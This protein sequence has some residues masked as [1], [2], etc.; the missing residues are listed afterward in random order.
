MDLHSGLPYWIIKNEL[1]DYFNPLDAD[2]ETEVVIIGSGITGSLV[3]HE[4]CEAKIPCVMIDK[5]TIATG[6][7]AASTSQLQYEI[8]VP[9]SE[10]IEKVGEEKAVKA[11]KDCL[12]SITD[13]ENIYKKIKADPDFR[14]VPTTLLASN[15]KGLKLL[16]KEYEIRKKHDLPVDFL[17]KEELKEQLNLDAPGALYNETSAQMDCYKGATSILKYHLKQSNF[18][19]FSHTL[20]TDYEETSSGYK[21]LTEG[22]N[23]IKCKYVIIAAGFEAGEFLPKKVM[24]LLSTYVI[25]SQPV[26]EDML[27]KNRSLIWETKEPYL[28]MRTTVD[29]RIIVG[30]EDISFSN[31]KHRDSRLRNKIKKLEI[32]FKKMFPE[33]PFVT[34][35]AWCGT[36]SATKDGLPFI[37]AWP[38]KPNML[39]A[40][41]Y[42]G[43]GITFSMIAAQMI[44]NIVEDKEEPRLDVYGFNEDR[45]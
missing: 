7:S 8:D 5:R 41:G 31:P 3:A 34:D 9:L 24:D 11:Y 33:I 32:K 2:I 43:N 18:Q 45:I 19:L 44:R 15:R 38:E 39:F 25:I 13:L 17:E 4:L 26:Y 42:G 16:K 1:F 29:N 30:G 10:L 36:F 23:T 22:G 40:L 21:L 20:I 27:W 37:G 6:S 35:M 12:D 14:R 28:Y